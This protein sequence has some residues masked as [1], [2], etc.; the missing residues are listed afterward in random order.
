M[1]IHINC[2]M[3]GCANESLWSSWCML[4]WSA[5]RFNFTAFRQ[6]QDLVSNFSLGLLV[7]LCMLYTYWLI[8][9]LTLRW[10]LTVVNY[11]GNNHKSII[12]PH[13]L[14][15]VNRCNLLLQILHVAWFLCLCVCMSVCLLGTWVSCAKTAE[16]IKMLF[17]AESC[18]FKES[19]VSWGSRFPYGKEHFEEDMCRPTV[20]YLC[21]HDAAT[22]TRGFAAMR[23][24]KT[25]MRSCV[26]LV[27]TLASYV[28]SSCC[29][30]ID[31][32]TPL[33][34]TTA[35]C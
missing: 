9:I 27:L 34:W 18:G 30:D 1:Y 16:L 28:N 15:T 10:K 19:C 12:R 11:R 25:V 3:L 21:M 7:H 26:R 4:Y 17:G 20:M 23:G 24:D 22:G 2:Y 8:S 29:Y 35:V 33:I 32:V 14:H 6:Q 5:G 31:S 13:R